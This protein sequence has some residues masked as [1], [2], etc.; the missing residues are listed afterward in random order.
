M[1]R[2]K[3]Y[4]SWSQYSLWTKSKREFWKRY[5]LNEDRSMNKNFAKGNELANALEYDDDGSSSSDELLEFVLTQV[6]KLDFQEFKLEVELS[7]NEKTL[8]FLDSCS[9]DLTVFFEYKTGKD[10]WTQELVEKHE[11]L[12]FYATALYIKSGRTIIPACKLF[13]I[14]TEQT[15]SDGLKY[16]G[17]VQGFERGFT[18]E[19]VE[20]FELKLIATIDEIEVW[21]YVELEL[22]EDEVDRYIEL[23]DIIKAATA[24]MDLIK[25]GIQLKM[26]SE[27]V[28]YASATNGKFMISETKSWTYSDDLSTVQK[29]FAKQIKIAQTQEQKD[30]VAKCELKPSLRF[31][32]NK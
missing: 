15:E 16:T 8:S 10:A 31:S 30:G 2:Q 17:L 9:A 7:N 25:L 23:S 14:E 13:W 22:E 1:I 3:D 26:E 28:K 29:E 5:G 27:E 18:L 32:L 12:L 20:S 19:E 4:L 6:P 11:Q 24:E 21:E